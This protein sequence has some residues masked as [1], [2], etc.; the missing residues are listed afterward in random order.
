MEVRLNE[1][2]TMDILEDKLVIL[3]NETNKL[4]DINEI[5][6]IIIENIKKN[7]N[8]D[9]E[10]IINKIKEEYELD[11]SDAEIRKDIED[12]TN[13]LIEIGVLVRSK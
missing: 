12:F 7:N 2:L 9:I 4:I 5:G 10:V 8:L 6:K 13:N 11:C 1:N 3:N